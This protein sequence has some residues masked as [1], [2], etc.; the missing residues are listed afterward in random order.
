[1]SDKQAPEEV[2]APEAV[3]VAPAVA[4]EQVPNTVGVSEP[5]QAE[6][7]PEVVVEAPA[8]D[9]GVDEVV[10]VKPDVPVS[11]A[12]VLRAAVKEKV[13]AVLAA[14]PYRGYPSFEDLLAVA[15]AI[16]DGLLD[17]EK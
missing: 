4:A 7:A 3:N 9:A 17:E 10:V 6:P 5:Q 1:M 8:A 12:E 16:V 14:Q 13:R 11:S 15:D 2:K